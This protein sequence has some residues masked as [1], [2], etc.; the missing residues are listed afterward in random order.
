MNWAL[1]MLSLAGIRLFLENIN[2]W[3]TIFSSEKWSYTM[4][5]TI[6]CE[7]LRDLVQRKRDS[8]NLLWMKLYF[9]VISG[10]FRYGIRVDPSMWTPHIFNEANATTDGAQAVFSPH[11]HTSMSLIMCECWLHF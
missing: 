4:K 3:E 10:N 6:F 2:K 8:C 7:R 9:N 1:L 5:C 11:L